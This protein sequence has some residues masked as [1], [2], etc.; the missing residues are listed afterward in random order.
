MNIHAPKSLNIKQSNHRWI[1]RFAFRY[2]DDN[3]RSVV[4]NL[5]LMA[6]EVVRVWLEAIT[7]DAHVSEP[8]GEPIW[9]VRFRTRSAARRFNKVWG[10]KLMGG[11]RR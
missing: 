7:P 11:E 6:H 4:E 3:Q 9:Y 8:R 1:V 2:T 5:G 10:G